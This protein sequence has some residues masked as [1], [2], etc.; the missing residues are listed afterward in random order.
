MLKNKRIVIAFLIILTGLAFI[1]KTAFAQT[2]AVSPGE[3]IT[4]TAKNNPASADDLKGVSVSNLSYPSFVTK[5]ESF[6]SKISKGGAGKLVFRVN[7]DAQKGSKG[8]ISFTMT[9]NM[10]TAGMGAIPESWQQSI[11]IEV[12]DDTDNSDPTY[13]QFS[14]SGPYE[15]PTEI[16]L[17]FSPTS[18]P[19]SGDALQLTYNLSF[20]SYV[21]IQIY[22]KAGN[23]VRT[24]INNEMRTSGSATDVWDGKNDSGES[25]PE[26]IYTFVINGVNSI[27]ANNTWMLSGEI[28]I[29]NLLPVAKIDF[30]KADTP[31]YNRYTIMGTADDSHLA[32]YALNCTDCNPPIEIATN[33]ENVKN[34]IL[35][36]LDAT[37]LPDGQYTIELI[38]VDFAGNSSTSIF[39]L[40]LDRVT[41]SVNIHINSVSQNIK[42]GSEGYVPSSDDPDAWIDDAPPAGSTEMDTWEW[43]ANIKYSGNQSHSDPGGAGTYGHYLIHA[44]DTLMLNTNDNIIQYVYLDPSNPPEEILLQFYTDTGDGEHRAFWGW[45]SIT[46]GGNW[47]SASLYHMGGLPDIGKW[48]RLKI[49]ASTLGLSGKEVKGIAFVTYG[50]KAYWDKTTKSSD[51]NE[52]Q[53]VSWLPASQIASEDATATL[54][55]YST[56]RDASIGLSIYDEGNNLIKTLIDEFKT[57]GPHQIVWDGTDSSGNQTTGGKY[58]FQ[59]SS[60]DGSIDSNAYALV[61][62]DWSSKMVIVNTSVADSSGNRYEIDITNYVVHKYDALNNLK[63][64]IIAE[65]L[66][67]NTF[68]P[69]ALG[70]DIND[71]LFVVDYNHGKIFK[72]NLEGYYLNELPYPPDIPWADKSIGFSN[73]NA[74]LLDEN[75]DIFVGNQDG[76]EILKLS[77]GRG[78]IDISNITAEIRV[79]YENSL[80]YATIPIIGTASARGFDRYTV[81]YGY[82]DSPMAWTTL[83]TS[84]TEVFDDYR[85]LP[86]A[87]TL[88]GNLATWDTYNV[89]M[90]TYTIRLTVYDQGGN[91]KHDS[92][93]VEVGRII[94]WNGGTLASSD[95][96]VTLNIP[97]GAVA[98]DVDLFSIK[99]VD[100][101]VAPPVN[102]PDLTLVGK[103]YE[104]IPPGYRFLKSVTLKMYYTS[105]QVG[106]IDENTLKIYRWNP[107]IQRWIF[108]YADLNTES[109]VLTTTLTEFNDYEV[110]YAVMSDPPPAPVIYQP[111]SPT[112]M[113]TI[114]VFGKA[115]P[116]VSVEI[117]V[118]GVLQ[119]ATKADENTGNFVKTGI[120]LD[121]GD[122]YLTAQA[123]DPVGNTS[124]LS[125]PVL[126][127]VIWA[128]PTAVNSIA[129]K[130]SDFSSDFTDDVA[131]G[132]SLYIE[133]AGTDADPVS[134]DST[135]ATLS[136][137][138]TDPSGISIQLIETA[139]DSGIYRGIVRVGETSN[140][141]SGTIAVSAS[142]VE[143]IFATSDVDPSKQD[144][145]N[146]VDTIPPPA[147]VISSPTHPSLTQDTFEV[148]LGEWSNKSYSYGAA[149]I[150]STDTSSTGNYSV[151]LV[152]TEIG[153]DFA[154]YIRT[155]DFDA[156][157]YPVVSFDYRI[158]P[159]VKVNLVAYVNG[160]WKE[161]VFTD[162]PKTVETFDEDLYRTIGQIKGVMAD[163]TWHHAEFN[164]Y[165]MLKNDDPSQAKYIVEELFFADFNLPAW[166]E[167]IMGGENQQGATYH[168]DNLIITGGGKSI[169]DPALTW[170]PGDNSVLAYSYV[171]D[172]NPHTVPDEVSEGSSNSV[173]FFDIPDGVWYFH[174][175]S[176]DGGGNWGPANHY[177]VMIDTAGPIASS[178]EP[179]DGS[180]S[181]SLDVKIRITDE[182]DS[183]VNPDTIQLKL[184][185]TVYGMNSGGLNYDEETGI[186]TFSLWKIFP[187]PDPWVNG[188]RIQASLIIADDYAGNH[189]Q[190]VFSWSWTV[191]YSKLAGGYLSLLTTQGGYTPT[192]SPDGKKIAFM[193]ERSGNKDIWVIDAD[194]YAE[195]R[196]TARQL[197]MD[198]GHD[199]HPSWSPVDD[200]IAF[201]SI[202]DGHEH[203]WI[204]NADGTGLTQLTTGNYYDSHPAWSPDGTKIAFSR[205]DE[206]WVINADGTDETQITFESVE[207]YLDPVW[208]ADGGRIAFTKSL[209][210]DQVAVMDAD[211]KNQKVLTESGHDTLPT[212]SKQT[213]QI[214]FVTMRNEKTSTIWIMDGNGSSEGSYIDNESMWWDSDPEQSPVDDNIAFQSTRNGTW[215]IW[216]KT[217]VQLTDITASPNPF[218]PNDDGVKDTVNIAFNLLGGAAHVDLK[219]YDEGN[220][221]IATLIDDE[222]AT[223]GENIVTWDGRDDRVNVASDGIYV[224]KITMPGSSGADPVVRSGTIRLDTTPP[225]FKDFIIPDINEDSVGSQNI[226]VSVLDDSGVNVDATKLQYGIAA[227]AAEVI[228][229]IIQWTDFGSG[230]SGS[231]NLSWS[232]YSGKYL[233]IRC[234]AED[235]IGNGG[236][237]NIQ[238]LLI[239]SDDSDSDGYSIKDEIAAGS[240][241]SNPDSKPGTTSL[242]LSQGFNLISFPAETLYYGNIYM[243]MEALG[244]SDII[245]KILVSDPSGQTFNELG[246]NQ[247]G[248]FYG[249]NF[250]LESSQS[251]AGFIVYAKQDA[252]FTFTSRYCPTW[253]LRVGTNLVGTPC[254][255]QGMTAFQLL[256]KI[257][258]EAMI[259]SIQR[260]NPD[261]GRFETAVYENGQPVGVDFPIVAGEGYFIHMKQERLGFKP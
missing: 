175:R 256:E 90:G 33:Q 147:P 73:P 50:G 208:S 109:N 120:Q 200:R 163:G 64:S 104:M 114:T 68:N 93:K 215:N 15:G 132:D 201:V 160:M 226:S 87:R 128:Q 37:S 108:V 133:L 84:R 177:Q 223:A 238:K 31:M 162:D 242:S 251:L 95:G 171:L 155:T 94:S 116:S 13:I 32:Y 25:L 234:Y 248:Q 159:D 55:N 212:W 96:L 44:D 11:A 180:A 6:P 195:L 257:R 206:I 23:L 221:L 167:L 42:L 53:K 218:S 259:S 101:S 245:S 39:P 43:N 91:Y 9:H 60:P 172:Q 183:G 219:I 89:P 203:I 136:S 261:T 26:G 76:A 135:T 86:S 34:G 119:G 1:A 202:M 190:N 158:P 77:T 3:T 83:I 253:S 243:L 247:T 179:S 240:D 47:G 192:W 88:Y 61:T 113:K 176:L 97:S 115:S 14:R 99:S 22:D 35:G 72:L 79:P 81:E 254:A 207:W 211:G 153:G 56:S 75:G 20:S 123:V 236:Y 122:N 100:T 21:T 92:V 29:D 148:D 51:Y 103:I 255:A 49:P 52:T 130:T 150:R 216:V 196:G 144:S 170:S 54:I 125:T 152:N 24:L 59:F 71:N 244:G 7:V 69:I 185:D 156:Q 66:G 28:A 82:G 260:F 181:G 30:I 46:T 126:V 62:G 225:S 102:D 252:S 27:D 161:V 229:G 151:K 233:Y 70:L 239:G 48:I 107:I 214:I 16:G 204:I 182:G 209:Y 67:V 197:T 41:N 124:P 165:N 45:N 174:V 74:L 85:P 38:A 224:Y 187:L 232:N 36:I 227:T 121:I 241:P 186:L 235:M 111:A 189:L 63:F 17:Q 249:Q 5:I 246:Y 149:V 12:P 217:Q 4:F 18:S 105:A 145:L 118:D 78:V 157:Q 222:L 169:N 237:S 106:T 112:I 138:V 131:I 143:T 154:S 188:E 193:S 129:F 178:P 10:Q 164:L 173:T 140:V 168:V 142:L 2:Y 146:T 19:G 198:A 205:N 230:E 134:V 80:V 250:S 213:D 194:D 228:P 191:D 57:A 127:R 231:I 184:N 258:N 40:V 199:H 139:P 117:F 166:M 220:R 58:Y 137:S 65:T 141:S 8:T 210:I 110:Y 98:D